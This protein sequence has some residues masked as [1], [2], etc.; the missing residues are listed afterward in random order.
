MAPAS[1][2]LSSEV[3]MIVKTEDGN[4]SHSGV[5]QVFDRGV[6]GGHENKPV[7]P[8]ENVV[9]RWHDND[10]TLCSPLALES[11]RECDFT[12]HTYQRVEE[13]RIKPHEFRGLGGLCFIRAWRKSPHTGAAS[14]RLPSERP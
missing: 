11:D 9:E 13:Y 4:D 10:R 14:I 7:I 3:V 6:I 1:I 12:A 5:I 8:K 2:A